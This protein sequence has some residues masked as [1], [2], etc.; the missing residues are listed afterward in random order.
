VIEGCVDVAFALDAPPR[1]RVPWV[2]ESPPVFAKSAHARRQQRADLTR[3]SRLPTIVLMI[4]TRFSDRNLGGDLLCQN[5][6][7]GVA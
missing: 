3:E 2:N 1:R 4:A 7:T 6:D 5:T